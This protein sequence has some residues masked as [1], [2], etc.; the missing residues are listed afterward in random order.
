MPIDESSPPKYHNLKPQRAGEPNHNPSGKNGRMRR[1]IIAAFLDETDATALGQA[2][3]KKIG[4]SPETSRIYALL[5]RTW[6]AAMSRSDHARKV[7]LEQY[8]GKPKQQMDVAM[9][10]GCPVI[11]YLPAND[12]PF[13]PQQSDAGNDGAETSESETSKSEAAE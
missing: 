2:L 9:N 10:N 13:A 11:F 5:H 8:A 3:I 6:I 7:L 4:C 12:R 1:D